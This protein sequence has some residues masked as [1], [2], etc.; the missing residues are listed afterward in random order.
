LEVVVVLE[1][2]VS[3]LAVPLND[4]NGQVSGAPRKEGTVVAYQG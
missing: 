1:M 2:L 4:Q 3:S